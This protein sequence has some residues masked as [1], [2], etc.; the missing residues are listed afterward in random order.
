LKQIIRSCAVACWMLLFSSSPTWGQDI[1]YSQYYHAPQNINPALTGIFNGDLR[2]MANF[3][4][5]WRS[6]AV[7]YTTYTGAFDFKLFPKKSQTSFWGFGV[8][9]NYD[10]MGTPGLN[11]LHLGLSGSYTYILNKNNL[12]TGGVQLGGAQKAFKLDRLQWD[13][14]WNGYEYVPSLPS[15]ESFDNLSVLFGDVSLGLNYRLQGNDERSKLDLGAGYYHVNR[16]NQNFYDDIDSRL[17][18]RLAIHAIGALKVARSVDV[19]VHGLYQLQEKANEIVPGAGAKIYLNQQRGK[20][21]ALVFAANWRV[22]DAVIPAVE[23]HYKTW[24]A[25]FSY[26]INYSDFNVAT[27]RRG[28]PELSLSYRILKVKPLPVYKTCPIY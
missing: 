27:G 13:G 18:S 23:V 4:D 20:E 2:F 3:R 17:P 16:P 11:T 21:L 7:P 15:G 9:F 5:Q 28:G 6:V 24:H 8:V 25:G 19:L 1:H 12:I 22:R 10:L 26:D 14:Q